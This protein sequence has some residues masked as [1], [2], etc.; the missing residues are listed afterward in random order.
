MSLSYYNDQYFCNLQVC[1]T[2]CWVGSMGELFA[3]WE[4]Q[5]PESH[6]WRGKGDE[7]SI[8]EVNWYLP[9]EIIKGFSFLMFDTS[10]E[11]V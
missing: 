7:V 9:V 10:K 2:L 3:Y 8:Q 4:T 11:I 1:S 5:V 6:D